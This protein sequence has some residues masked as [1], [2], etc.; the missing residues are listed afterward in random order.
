VRDIAHNPNNASI[1]RAI[2]Q[3]AKSLGITTIAEGVETKEALNV[4][5]NIG[6]NEIQG[7]LVAKPML[8]NEIVSFIANWNPAEYALI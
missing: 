7:Y 6:C 3:M 4:L 5:L 1:V 2:V 8:P